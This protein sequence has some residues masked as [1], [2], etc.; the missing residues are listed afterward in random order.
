MG[1]IIVE[2]NCAAISALTDRNNIVVKDRV[3]FEGTGN[4]L[5]AQAELRQQH[6]GI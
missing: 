3:I 6:L 2:R 5:R 4:E 1:A